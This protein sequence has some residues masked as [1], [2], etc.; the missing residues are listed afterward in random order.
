[1]KL[2]YNNYS[3]LLVSKKIQSCFEGRK[4]ENRTVFFFYFL[5]FFFFLFLK[6]GLTIT[7]F[8]R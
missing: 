7:L 5:S 1:M 8:E 2:F 6:N 4:C 3:N